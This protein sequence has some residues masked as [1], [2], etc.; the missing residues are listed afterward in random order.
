M[1]LMDWMGLFRSWI[2][3]FLKMKV[4]E[5][6][7]HLRNFTI[8]REVPENNLQILLLSL[9]KC[10]SSQKLSLPEAVKAYFFL[11]AANM[12]EENET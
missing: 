4:Q 8:L 5:Y 12:S 9:K 10:I 7:A 11:S 2:P 6:T 3:Y 1:V